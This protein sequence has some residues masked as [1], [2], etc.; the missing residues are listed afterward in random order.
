MAGLVYLPA[1]AQ[2]FS[3]YDLIAAV[4]ALRANQGL[5]PYQVDSGLM[6]YAQE[7]SEYQART[8]ISTHTHSD[9]LSP[10][11]YGITENIANGTTSFMT[12]NLVINQIWADA[13]HMN[14]MVGYESGFAGVGIATSGDMVYITLDVRPGKSAATLAPSAGTQG[15][16][17]WG[18][19]TRRSATT[20]T[21]FS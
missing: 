16:T 8:G 6:S 13:I 9:G 21:P 1:S 11:A 12:L 14:T 18:R 20:R 4:N 5:E 15:S 7:H 10:R 3:A 2:N 17:A 19:R